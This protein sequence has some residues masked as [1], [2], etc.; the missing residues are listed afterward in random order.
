[1]IDH[2]VR[3]LPEVYQTIYN[4]PE[5]PTSRDCTD[6][7]E[8]IIRVVEEWQKI[9][10][11]PAKVLDIGCAQ[12]YYCFKLAEIGADCHGID[13]NPANIE[14]CEYINVTENMSCKFEYRSLDWQFIDEI[15]SYDIVLALSVFHHIAM[16]GFDKAFDM[17]SAICKKADIVISEMAVK[18]EPVYWNKTLPYDYESWFSDEKFYCEMAMNDTHLSGVQRPF[19]FSSNKYVYCKGRIKEFDTMSTLSYSGGLNLPYKRLYFKGDMFF[20]I[21][22]KSKL[23]MQHSE[24]MYNEVCN[25]IGI[26]KTIKYKWFP[27]LVASDVTLQYATC[28][29]R[30]EKGELLYDIV[31]KHIDLPRDVILFD[32]L[33]NLIELETAGYYH[34]DIRT[35]NIVLTDKAFLIDIGAITCYNTDCAG[36]STYKAFFQLVA[37]LMPF[38]LA[39]FMGEMEGKVVDFKEIKKVLKRVL[40]G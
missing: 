40:N 36:G 31:E 12:G 34:S 37:A 24:Y 20:K 19:M 18:E 2:Y 13:F 16:R 28:W 39:E 7:E 5:Y 22:R 15:Q 27:E 9:N 4:H 33:D 35:W 8:Y 17:F 26:L 29:Q 23:N 11:R 30:I 10:H 25:E 1:M 6:R 38:R 32:V 14:L 21:A 3:A